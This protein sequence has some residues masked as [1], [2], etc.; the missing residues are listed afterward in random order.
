MCVDLGWPIHLL[1][2]A[3]FPLAIFLVLRHNHERMNMSLSVTKR[4]IQ[5]QTEQLCE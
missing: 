5:K 4:C 1:T 2:L 3:R